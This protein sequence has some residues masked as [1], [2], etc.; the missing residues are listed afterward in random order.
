MIKKENFSKLLKALHFRQNQNIYI[1]K[2]PNLKTEL[3]VDIEKQ[4]LIYPEKDGLRVNGQQTCNFKQA[5]NFVVFECVH[6]L[7]SQEYAPKHIELEPTWQVGHGASGGRADI[8]VKDNDDNALLIIECKTAGSEFKKAWDSTQVKPTQLFSYVQQV[9]STQFIALYASDLVDEK[10]NAD[11][12]LMSMVDNSKLLENNKKLKGYK[13]AN[14]TEEIYEVWVETYKKDYATLGLFEATQAYHIGKD[15]YSLNDLKTVTSRDIQGKYHE[16]ATIMRQHNVSGR[17]NAFD[18]LVN[19]FLCKVVDETDNSNELKFYWK[20]VAYD[21]PFSLQ[22]RL[23]HLYKVGMKKFLGEDITYIE[24]QQIEDAFSVF[25]DKPNMTKEIIQGFFKELKFFTNNDFAFVDVH[26]EALFYQNFEVLL[27]IV[28]MLQD[29]KLTG[30]EDNQF[31]GDMFE[32]F[33]DQGVKQSEGQ[34]FTPMPIVKFIV[35]ALPLDMILKEDNPKAIDYA[36]GAGHFLTEVANNFPKEQ[37][38][39]IV[40]IEKEYRLSKVAKV[41]AFMYGQDEVNVVY[42]DALASCEPIKNN[43]YSLLVANPPYSVKGFLETLNEEERA[44]YVLMQSLDKKSLV[45]NNAIEC[46]F[47]ERAKQLLKKD[48]VAG[49]ILPSSILSK[50]SQNIASSKGNVYVQTREILLKYFDIVAIAE[51]GAGTFGKTGTNTVT[52]F[53]KRR[54]D[55]PNMAQHLAYM[56]K[57]WFEGDFTI[58]E[59][60]K[61]KDLLS[62]YATHIE[63]DLEVYKTLLQTTYNEELFKFEIFVEYKQEFEKLSETKN[64]KKQKSYKALNTVE[65]KKLEE[66]KLLDYIRLIEEDKL[67][68]FALAC[69][70]KK[71]VIIVKA[72]SNGAENKKFLGYEWSGRKGDEGIKYLTSGSLLKLEDAEVLENILNLNNIQTPLYNPQDK[73][74]ESKINTL[75]S[76]N[77]YDDVVEIPSKLEDF[78]SKANLVDMLDFSGKEF[79]KAIRLSP[80]KKV[81]IDSKWELKKLAKVASYVTTKV[82]VSD[83]KVENYITTD[84]ILQNR[85]GIS[86]YRG[87]LNIERVTSYE[88]NDILISNIRPYLKKI[89]IATHK[90]GCSNDVLVVRS[91]NPAVIIPKYLFYL[92]SSDVFFDY[93]MSSKKGIKMPRG[94]KEQ[95]LKYSI[96]LVKIEIQEKII[97]KCEL[98]DNEVRKAKEEIQSIQNEIDVEVRAI[99]GDM[100]KIGEIHKTSSGGTPL[101]SK[102]EFYD[103]GNIPWVNSGEVKQGL[104]LNTKNKITQLGLDNSSAKIFPKYTVLIAMYGATVGQV[105]ILGIEASTNQAVCGLFPNREKVLPLY[106]YF[107][108]NSKTEEFIKL[109]VGVARTN[110]SQEIIKNFKI[111]LPSLSLQKEIV[112]KIQKLETKITKAKEVLKNTN[113]RKES[114]LKEYLS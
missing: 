48:A 98:V 49:I 33:L 104:I 72:P 51:F 81:Q 93:V 55:N 30:G 23:N 26:N 32:G 11:Y 58:N 101:S 2:F 94:D 43:D 54:A 84:N 1:K 41:S 102:N 8:L 59:V 25:R 75:I 22:D 90:G 111:P 56:V 97:Q 95:I 29:I 112:Q 53:I 34:F 7:L 37:H 62:V 79:S 31:L 100:V 103:K 60:F 47:I 38:K 17:E 19:L 96:P 16:F 40:G 10:I 87:T 24:N 107:Y 39:N 18:K 3:K 71:E 64:R 44:K 50:G 63:V 109:S 108:L 66:Q 110:I 99:N 113:S 28:K 68:Y 20:G 69:L 13:D 80:K 42:H 12:Y 78:V 27:K 105:G 114:I 91:L 52:L 85:Q 14:S 9:R 73:F 61:Q 88:K 74:D 83:I 92:L 82:N 46:F 5:E 57:A 86:T 21:D 106:S 15:K 36:C 76:K 70:N 77:F 6:R 45:A 65:K 67:Y 89:W 4:I 35:N